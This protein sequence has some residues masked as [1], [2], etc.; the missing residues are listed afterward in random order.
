MLENKQLQPESDHG[1]PIE[2]LMVEKASVELT[3]PS[4]SLRAVEG[5]DHRPDDGTNQSVK[6][7]CI[8]FRNRAFPMRSSW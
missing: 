8:G 4:R 1:R 7:M 3:K 5:G 2:G 6:A